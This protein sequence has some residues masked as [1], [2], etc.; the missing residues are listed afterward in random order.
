MANAR[1]PS[2][3]GG[4]VFFW[5][6]E[7]P[8]K[9]KQ[10]YSVLYHITV[11]TQAKLELTICSMFLSQKHWKIHRHIC[12][13]TKLLVERVHHTQLWKNKEKE[14]IGIDIL[15]P[16]VRPVYT[17]EKKEKSWHKVS[18]HWTLAKNATN[19]DWTHKA[20]VWSPEG[21]T[22]WW[23]M[24]VKEHS[25]ETALVSRSF[26]HF[27]LATH[28]PEKVLNMCFASLLVCVPGSR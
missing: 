28:P 15:G 6:I 9:T 7:I 10:L 8:R 5:T 1:Q 20:Y 3:K 23:S 25:V 4:I 12:W 22:E 21:T 2:L 24:A 26:R 19:T 14:K 17:E 16:H 13:F 27:F 18:F 11:R